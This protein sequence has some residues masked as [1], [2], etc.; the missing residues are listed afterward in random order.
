M[1][2]AR[3]KEQPY[4]SKL[5]GVAALLESHTDDGVEKDKAA[6]LVPL[7]QVIKS[8]SQPRRYFDPLAQKQLEISVSTHGI[9]EPLLVRPMGS[10]RYEIV[11][12]ERRYQAA[13]AVGLSHLPVVIKQLNDS[14]AL[15]LALVENLQRADLNPLEETEGILEL[16]SLETK[17]TKEEVILLL[18][19][20]ENEVKG[21]VTQNVLGNDVNR[22]IIDLFDALGRMSWSS[23]VSSRLPLLKLP[24]DVLEVLRQGKIEYTKAC[25]IA[26]L[27]DEDARKELMASA[28]AESLSLREIKERI[29]N[30]QPQPTKEE[31]FTR[32]DDVSKQVKKSKKFLMENPKKKKKLESLLAQIEKLFEVES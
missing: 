22:K 15:Q 10:G 24:E 16:L 30:A 8:S 27:K 11:A 31:V 25:A 6:E 21:K 14:E 13:K 23:F 20:L 2:A 12:G 26:R 28:I 7:E 19:R 3:K 5:R 29:K 1:S 17:L 4:T 18:Y 32:L 9:L